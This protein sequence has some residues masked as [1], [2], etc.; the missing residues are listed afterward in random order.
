MQPLEEKDNSPL[1]DTEISR[2]IN[3]SRE[4]GY[5]KQE[6]IPER[7]LVDFKPTSIAQ[8]AT[9]SDQEKKSPNQSEEVDTNEQENTRGVAEQNKSL[10]DNALN[11]FV[12]DQTPETE[13]STDESTKNIEKE[14]HSEESAVS[15]TET[16]EPPSEKEKIEKEDP[17]LSQTP[18]TNTFES[19]T[20]EKDLLEEGATDSKTSNTMSIEKAKQEGIEIGKKLAINTMENEQQKLLE[21]FQLIV[22]NIK[23][24][25]SIDKTGLTSSILKVITSLA[26]ERAGSIID[27][28][29]KPFR[30]KVSSFVD[31]IDEASKRLI[32]NL[33]PK[34]S[35]LIKESLVEYFNDRDVEIRENSELFRG[36]FI[37][38]MGAIEIG[39]L[40]SEQ[41]SI[42]EKGNEEIGKAEHFHEADDNGTSSEIGSS[43]TTIIQDDETQAKSKNN[44]NGK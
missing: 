37:L 25:E 10:P 18:G 6:K 15:E 26:S 3:V 32:F 14:D 11:E 31:K 35:G 23:N 39:D 40:I 43:D 2:L 21:T 33:N 1:E 24:K 20:N 29:P 5:K 12:E 17:T 19:S 9:L 30:E 13:K 22:D 34:D 42:E 44:D 38:Q 36:D 27:E 16:S 41:I 4:L 8:I 28:H 7:N